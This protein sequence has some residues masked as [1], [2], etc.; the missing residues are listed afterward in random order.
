M[1]T[2]LDEKVLQFCGGVIDNSL[3]NML[4]IDIESELNFET[5]HH[6]PYYKT[7]GFIS[8]LKSN[9][10]NFTILSS[11]IES[12]HSKINELEIFINECDSKIDVICLQECWISDS[13]DIT[14]I[15][16]KGYSC[17]VQGKSCSNKGG[18]IIYVN[19]KFQYKIHKQIN[20]SNIWE[21][22][23]VEIFGGGLR[24][25]ILLGNIYRPPRDIMINYRTFIDEFETVLSAIE[26]SNKNILIT[27][28]FN[29]NLLKINEKH[30]FKEFLELFFTNG[31]YP[32]ITFPTRFSHSNGTLIDNIVS[33]L[34]RNTII[35]NSGI[36]LKRFSDHQPYFTHISD[37]IDKQPQTKYIKVK[38]QTPQNINKL[39]NELALTDI[40]AKLDL[41]PKADPNTNYDIFE[42]TIQHAKQ[43]TMPQK[44]LKFNKYKHK[45]SKWITQG[46]IKSIRYRDKLYKMLRTTP[47]ERPEHNA[48]KINLTTYNGI[49]KRMIR[50]ASLD[51]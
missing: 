45:K 28:D 35:S 4:N 13:D 42:D 31:Y 22:I 50:E 27:G 21:G 29:M 5:L 14:Q 40:T 18:L 2:V 20:N 30:I 10:K 16:L 25:N 43:K 48:M 44:I 3:T 9:S 47:I 37:I 32:R 17:I 15:Q 23:I 8:L 34:K 33:K 24:S 41:N 49:L 12:I 39:I 6:S 36:L 7:N 51:K 11:N 38:N 19:E 46:I 26:T 1:T